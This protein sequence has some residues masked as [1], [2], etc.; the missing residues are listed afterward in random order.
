MTS[1]LQKRAVRNYRNCRAV[2][3]LAVG[4]SWG[5]LPT[6][7]SFGGCR[8]GSPKTTLELRG[9]TRRFGI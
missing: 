5:M 4:T 9:C 3:R 2:R 7:S 6:A 1:L 8:G